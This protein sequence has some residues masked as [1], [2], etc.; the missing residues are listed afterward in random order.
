[1]EGG[2]P[3]EA[4]EIASPLANM[5]ISS[6]NGDHPDK[7]LRD[8]IGKNRN[9]NKSIRL[10]A[11]LT[12]LQFTM[13]IYATFLLYFMS[14]TVDHAP[15]PDTPWA[16]HVARRWRQLLV[17]NNS[18]LKSVCQ[19]EQLNFDQKI[20]NDTA[21]IMAKTELFQDV[22]KHQQLTRGCETLSELLSLPSSSTKASP[23]VTVI[24][25]HHKRKTLCMQLDA[26]LQQTLPFYSVWVLAFATPIESS[27]R[28]I[29]QAYNDSRIHF[30][31]STYDF[32]YYGRFQFSLQAENADYL[33]FLD[34]D[35]LPGKKMLQI[36]AHVSGTEKYGRSLL[37]SIGRVLPFRQ[38]DFSFPSYR[39]FRSKE[40]GLYLPD[41]AYN[42]VVDRLLQVDFL[43]SSWF[44][45][46]DLVRTIFYE[47]PFT[48]ATG[49]DLHLSY[50]LQKY[51][52]ISSFVVPVDP[53][54]RAT[55]GDREHRL[56]YVSE[57]TVIRKDVVQIRDDQW[58]RAMS[59]G[60]VTQWATMHPQKSDVLFYAH[61]LG[62]VLDLAPLILRF[63]TM[64]GKKAFLVVSGGTH[65]PCEE[66]A[67]VLGWSP[68][69]CHERRFK[70]FDLGIGSVPA[71]GFRVPLF[72]Q[73]VTSM[74]GLIRIHSPALIITIAD[75]MPEVRAALSAST[76]G[77]NTSLVQLPRPD[78]EHALWM[79][80][81]KSASLRKWNKM[82]ISINVITQDRPLSLQRLLSSIST[83]YYLGDTIRL[84]FNL[85]RGVDAQTL[86]I[87]DDFHWPHGDKLI[88]RKIVPGGLI[89]AVSESW[90]NS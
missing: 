76:S 51:H 5:T 15:G 25:N 16:F 72:H 71:T 77:S 3:T 2:I 90:S 41:P 29:I 69:S 1:M 86:Q 13:A 11:G 79:A 4:A 12:C 57:T 31:T 85:D 70:I 27:L 73:I 34:D 52:G 35:M 61:S 36:L 32:K 19:H 43:S 28:Q 48:F 65:C 10:A 33:Y 64:P 47:M 7:M 56:A 60:Y 83:A 59:R 38:K 54:D 23:K 6:W 74:K 18:T 58:W 67:I 17:Q 50:Q 53:G 37:G 87:V 39:K 14:P 62:E 49:E 8:L 45:P 22:L 40:A 42:I 81:V 84:S 24:L 80:N 21:T 82:Q 55:W 68:N 89:R 46:A 20:S 44:L 63:R 78:I 88:R 75:A 30:M 9:G 26:L 66:A